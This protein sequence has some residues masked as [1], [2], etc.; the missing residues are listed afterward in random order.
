MKRFTSFLLIAAVIMGLAAPAPTMAAAPGKDGVRVGLH[1]DGR[2]LGPEDQ[3]ILLRGRTLV[4]LRV[5]METL[6]ATVAW[7][8]E[9]RSITVTKSG[10]DF[11]RLWVDNRL[12][13][14]GGPSGLTYDVCDVAPMI[15]E[16]RTYVPLRLVAGALGMGVEWDSARGL[17]SVDT[18]EA[19]ERARFF[20]LGI[21]GIQAGQAI[22][23]SL[24]LSLSHG[25]STAPGASRSCWRISA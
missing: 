3:A 7:E 13:C 9:H 18:T 24:S 23:D 20:D 4:P 10:G 15:I 19:G 22:T 11:I 6:G 17:V 14:Y 25:A 1:I 21:N 16:N 2:A 12:I 8:P 5:L